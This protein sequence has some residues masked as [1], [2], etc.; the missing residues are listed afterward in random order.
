MSEFKDQHHVIIDGIE[1]S[2]IQSNFVV[3]AI[4]NQYHEALED[5]LSSDVDDIEKETIA[6]ALLSLAE[7]IVQISPDIFA[8]DIEINEEGTARF[9]G[10]LAKYN[11]T[12]EPVDAELAEESE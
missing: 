10:S 8:A 6:P 11:T 9:T 3:E 4:E 1:L 7:V 5:V 2:P 12:D